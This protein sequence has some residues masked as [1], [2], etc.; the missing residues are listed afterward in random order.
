[1]DVVLDLECLPYVELRK[2]SKAHGL[3]ANKKASELRKELRTVLC[4]QEAESTKENINIEVFSEPCSFSQSTETYCVNDRECV[5]CS[6]LTSTPES[7][8]KVSKAL[9][10]TYEVTSP[11]VCHR[12]E[13]TIENIRNHTKNNKTVL[14]GNSVN[15][16][17]DSAFARR[18]AYDIKIRLSRRSSCGG[19]R[20]TGS[21]TPTSKPTTPRRDIRTPK[22]FV[23]INRNR[24]QA[25]DICKLDRITSRRLLVDKTRGL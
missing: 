8:K 15:L 18:K 12:K 16:P 14:S 25:A 19:D 4:V 5:P 20:T 7:D 22:P 13:I 11:K 3:K 21:S 9:N 10:R 24:A 1:M 23:N 2:L 6:G 17:R